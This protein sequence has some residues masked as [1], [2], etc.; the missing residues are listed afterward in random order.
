[1]GARSGCVNGCMSGCRYGGSRGGED[2]SRMER[3]ENCCLSE[4]AEGIV[5]EVLIALKGAV[6]TEG[7]NPG[8]IE[9][10]AGIDRL[11]RTEKHAGKSLGRSLVRDPR[12]ALP[13][14]EADN[15]LRGWQG[16]NGE[17]ASCG[18]EK[19]VGKPFKT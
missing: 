13:I 11:Q 8:M 3:S 2:D 4:P 18:L 10:L 12:S 5:D 1:M 9:A 17:S 7:F 16:N 6:H 14:K 15:A 19:G